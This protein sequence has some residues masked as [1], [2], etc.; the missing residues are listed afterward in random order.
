MTQPA[1]WAARR[2]AGA[3]LL[4]AAALGGCASI[5]PQRMGI[6]RSDYATH[7]RETNKEQLLLNI[8]AMRYGDA[9]LFLE[10]SSVIS[11]YTREGSLHADIALGPP[12][13][14]ADGGIGGSVLLRE[15]P[16]ITYTPLAGDRFARSLLSPIPPAALLGMI[17]S[18]WSADILF[19]LATRSI[20]G[21]SNGG[22]DPLFAHTAD[23]D[24]DRVIAVMGRLQRNRALQLHV[25]HEDGRKFSASA[26]ISPTLSDDEKA[27]IDYLVRTLKLPGDRRGEFGIAFGAAQIAPDQLT[28]GTRSMFEI[29]AEMAQ[30]VEVP[31]G[32]DD[33]RA[34]TPVADAGAPSA[35]VAIHSGSRKPADAH[36]AVRYRGRWFWIDG[37][38]A[39]SKRMFLLAQIL[40]SL[41]DTSGGASAPLVTIPTG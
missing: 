18:G 10:V 17:E 41:N 40:L 12:V 8:V 24:F 7:L 37:K 4:V 34:G 30:G 3:A 33:G 11:Q 5:G 36:V 32:D 16:T 27:D 38:D 26:R 6:D 35:L 31:A 14:E 9:P 25:E 28:I 23:S 19:K 22:R 2:M 21:I 13:D 1:S 29:F 15:T 20:N 39:A